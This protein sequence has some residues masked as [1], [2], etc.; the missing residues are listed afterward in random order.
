MSIVIKFNVFNG[1]IL[2]ETKDKTFHTFCSFDICLLVDISSACESVCI[3]EHI[4]VAVITLLASIC[5]AFSTF[6]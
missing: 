6:P 1:Y 3:D 5:P 2:H 4:S